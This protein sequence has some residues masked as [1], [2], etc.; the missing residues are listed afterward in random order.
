MSSQRIPNSSKV[1]EEVAWRYRVFETV[2]RVSVIGAVVLLILFL[3]LGLFNESVP[4]LPLTS[5]AAVTGLVSLLCFFL[6]RR[7]RLDLAVILYM[8]SLTLMTFASTYY[9][10]GVTGPLLFFFMIFPMLAGLLGN[11][12]TVRWVVVIVVFF[13]VVAAVMEW[14]GVVQVVDVPV[15]ILRPIRHITFVAT[16]VLSGVLV[17]VFMERTQ[18]ALKLANQREQSLVESNRQAQA[19]AQAEREARQR[20]VRTTLHIRETAARYVDY[21]SRIAAGDYTARVDV[22][23]LDVEVE[24]VR[25]FHALGE[26][27]NATVDALV[28]AITQ[29]EEAQRRYTEQSWQTFLESGH[30]QPGFVYRQKQ[31]IPESE[32]LPQMTQAVDK[33]AS[34]AQDEVAAVPLIINQQVIGAIG[35]QH[36]DGR[37]WSD[38]ELSLIEAVTGQPTGQT[39]RDRR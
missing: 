31:I 19:L 3:L 23:E 26:Y 38:E 10:G 9:T 8:T 15:D 35:G 14:I 37:P 1:R 30:V 25:E 24:G 28:S 13:W 17:S 18:Q 20:E 2:T 21:L 39:G 29:A 36:P 16:F 34:V 11:R 5:V 7:G 33:G 6:N 4:V 12:I 27:L 32:W 22:G